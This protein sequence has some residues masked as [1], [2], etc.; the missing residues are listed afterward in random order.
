MLINWWK[1]CDY[2][3]T[4]TQPCIS[5]WNSGSGFTSSV[6]VAT[7]LLQIMRIDC[8]W[9]CKRHQTAKTNLSKKNKVAGFILFDFKFYSKA[10]VFKMVWCWYTNKHIDKRKRTESR[11]RRPHVLFIDFWQAPRQSTRERKVL[12]QVGKHGKKW[13][14]TPFIL[15]PHI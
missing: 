3:P 4:G 14:S 8:T 12:D 5:P 1:Y 10:V 15:T 13:T 6:F 2:K 11:K 9:K 7:W